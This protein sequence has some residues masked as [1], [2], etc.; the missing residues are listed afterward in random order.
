MA[1]RQNGNVLFYILIA[2]FLLGALT[3]ALRSS[4]T[5]EGGIDKESANVKAQQIIRYGGEVAQAVQI[6]LD[7]G[8][9]ETDIRFAHPNADATYGT[10]T[11]NPQN[12]VFSSQGGKAT[13]RLAPT[14]ANTGDKWIFAGNFALPQVGSDRADLVALLNVTQPVCN[15]INSQLGIEST[16]AI[17]CGTTTA[18]IGTY[19][20]SPTVINP[21]SFT[22]LPVMQVCYRCTN[23]TDYYSYSAVLYAR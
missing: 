21:A 1:T 7:N 2:I 17:S 12:Q 6:I 10:I 14:G 9:S 5:M 23:I 13:Y 16:P 11:T 19:A 3:V 20:A 8:A 15:A 22:Q 18:F 4:G